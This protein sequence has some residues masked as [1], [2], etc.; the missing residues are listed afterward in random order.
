MSESKFEWNDET[1]MEFCEYVGLR[2]GKNED[3]RQQVKLLQADFKKLKEVKP[4]EVLL[5]TEDG[6]QLFERG[7]LVIG[8]DRKTGLVKSGNGNSIGTWLNGW[9]TTDKIPNP[10]DID[11]PEVL[12]LVNERYALFYKKEAA[13]EYILNNKPVMVSLS[14]VLRSIP[15]TYVNSGDTLV[16][17]IC[18]Y[19]TAF[20]KSKI[21]P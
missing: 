14:D 15:F 13:E 19:I 16:R 7:E 20:F 17:N 4:K 21:N 12:K 3:I 8:I 10:K 11:D 5:T 9:Y 18:D 1:S 2:I 6:V